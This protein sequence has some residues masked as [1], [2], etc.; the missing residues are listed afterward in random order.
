MKPPPL[1]P[2]S[3]EPVSADDEAARSCRRRPSSGARRSDALRRGPVAAERVEIAAVDRVAQPKISD[4]GDG[5]PD[6]DDRRDR[7]CRR[8]TPFMAA[9]LLQPVRH[10]AEDIAGEGR[11]DAGEDLGEAGGREA[12]ARA[13][14]SALGPAAESSAGR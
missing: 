3:S 5:D 1:Q 2:S 13:S 10:L 14:R 12:D 6:Q 9:R 11:A 8:S 7:R 4:D